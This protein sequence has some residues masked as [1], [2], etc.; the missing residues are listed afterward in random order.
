MR[1]W[2][3]RGWDARGRY[4]DRWRCFID[5]WDTTGMFSLHVWIYRAGVGE[6]IGCMH[7]W[8]NVYCY[9]LK[10]VIGDQKLNI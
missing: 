10:H 4:Q 6:L 1:R 7:D 9:K 5:G 3:S 2:R 8:G